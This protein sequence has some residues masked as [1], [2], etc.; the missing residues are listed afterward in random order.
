MRRWWTFPSVTCLTLLISHSKNSGNTQ[1]YAAAWGEMTDGLLSWCLWFCRLQASW[2][3]E[4]VKH[5]STYRL[6]LKSPGISK[7]LLYCRT[8]EPVQNTAICNVPGHLHCS[9][10]RF[11]ITVHVLWQI[12]CHSTTK[13][14]HLLEFHTVSGWISLFQEVFPGLCVGLAYTEL[15]LTSDITIFQKCQYLKNTDTL[16]QSYR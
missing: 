3:T 16:Y 6:L 7:V 1:V 12:S 9:C 13:Q 15:N 11:M 8:V 2:L 10:N 4:A 5:R 14:V